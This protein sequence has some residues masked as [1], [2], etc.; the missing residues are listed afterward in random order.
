MIHTCNCTTVL[1]KSYHIDL[2]HAYENL[3]LATASTRN[4]NGRLKLD[5]IENLGDSVLGTVTW[6]KLLKTEKLT[7]N[8]WEFC[9]R[10]PR[11]HANAQISGNFFKPRQCHIFQYKAVKFS[12]Y[13][14]FDLL[15]L[16][17]KIYSANIRFSIYSKAIENLSTLFGEM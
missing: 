10:W 8:V 15:F 13:T 3:M 17:P 2:A 6:I 16:F 9:V 12:V 5:N 11:S 14:N 1:G 7:E 4:E